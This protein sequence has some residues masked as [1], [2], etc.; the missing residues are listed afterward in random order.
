MSLKQYI[1]DGVY[2]D[3][4]GFHIVLTTEDGLSVSNRIFLEDSVLE[5]FDRYRKQLKS[6]VFKEAARQRF[7][8]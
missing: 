6:L 5:A 3:W 1:G 7:G 8:E 2:A 4:D